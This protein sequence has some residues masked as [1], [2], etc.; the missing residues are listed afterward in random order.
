MYHFVPT[1]QVEAVLNAIDFRPQLPI[2]KAEMAESVA[3]FA[4]INDEDRAYYLNSLLDNPLS[5][6]TQPELVGIAASVVRFRAQREKEDLE[7]FPYVDVK[8]TGWLR[9]FLEEYMN[10][11]RELE[12]VDYDLF[13]V[14]ASFLWREKKIKALPL[15]KELVP[16]NASDIIKQ[17][18]AYIY[19]IWN[20]KGFFFYAKYR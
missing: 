13:R 8:D 19:K 3:V 7:L 1:K 16:L 17:T 2:I 5:G 10:T 4:S 6:L 12:A 11:F 18:E 20:H 14:I 15:I 9:D